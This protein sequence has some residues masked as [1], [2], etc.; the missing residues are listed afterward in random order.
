MSDHTSV[1]EPELERQGRR[2]G[3]PGR[4]FL[5]LALFLALP[6]AVLIVLAHG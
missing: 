1:A 3:R 2:L 4:W 6:G 5:L